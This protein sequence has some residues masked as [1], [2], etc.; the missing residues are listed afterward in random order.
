MGENN[1]CKNLKTKCP[2]K[3]CQNCSLIEKISIPEKIKESQLS[4]FEN[5][6]DFTNNQKNLS[7]RERLPNRLQNF[8]SGIG[9]TGETESI[10]LKCEE[11]FALSPDLGCVE[12]GPGCR[13]FD[14]KAKKCIQCLFGW[15]MNSKYNCSKGK[16]SY[17][18]ETLKNKYF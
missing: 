11:N 14:P 17:S 2:Q 3:N 10:C 15:Y 12:S 16:K 6:S 5:I 18:K 13:I 1:K 4:N 7:I 9:V 8:K